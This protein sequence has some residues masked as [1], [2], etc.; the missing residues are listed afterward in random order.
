[1]KESCT[2]N[3][4]WECHEIKCEKWN[5]LVSFGCPCSSL[6]WRIRRPCHSHCCVQNWKQLWPAFEWQDGSTKTLLV[7]NE[8]R[9]HFKNT[10]TTPKDEKNPKRWW[11]SHPYAS[12]DRARQSQ[13][14]Y[15]I[16][17]VAFSVTSSLRLGSSAMTA[18]NWAICGKYWTMRSAA[19]RK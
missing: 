9:G 10:T 14:T 18:R 8:S 7:P 3:A 19:W 11:T 17:R 16:N 1:M 6:T 4:D 15:P 2:W 12:T 5:M 13:L